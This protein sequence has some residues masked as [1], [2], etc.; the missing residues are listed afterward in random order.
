MRPVNDYP[1]WNKNSFNKD[2]LEEDSEAES[3]PDPNHILAFTK[4]IVILLQI[5]FLFKK[6]VNSYNLLLLS[7]KDGNIYN[8]YLL[9]VL[10]FV[11]VIILNL[12][13]FVIDSTVFWRC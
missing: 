3:R 4:T 10:I 12:L 6:L 8:C 2:L 13:T 5:P 1:L 7:I 11:I 9:K